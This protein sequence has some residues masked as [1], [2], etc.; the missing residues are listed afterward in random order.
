MSIAQP[1]PQRAKSLNDRRAAAENLLEHLLG[2]LRRRQ[3]Q[4]LSGLAIQLA[5][6]RGVIC[7]R[8]SLLED[9]LAYRFQQRARH[10]DG[11]FRI[12]RPAR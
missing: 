4:V 6:V 12:A 11:A 1:I 5:D 8:A 9:V 10:C 3:L 2:V 7:R